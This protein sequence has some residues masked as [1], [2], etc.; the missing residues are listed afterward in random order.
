MLR[1]RTTRLLLAVATVFVVTAGAAYATGGLGAIIGADG[2]I[3]ACYKRSNGD[4]H[5]V[6][7][8]ATACPSGQ[9][10]IA[11]SQTGPKGDKGDKGDTGQQGI[12]GER[13]TAGANGTNGVSGYRINSYDFT[14]TESNTNTSRSSCDSDEV[15]V[16]GG[17]WLFTNPGDVDIPPRLIQSAPIDARTW[18]VKIDN[19]GSPRTWNYR[20][21]VICVRAS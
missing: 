14:V 17:A 18:E 15:L 6:P 12:Q 20:L 9:A 1:T 3:H 11:W 4:L 2:V 8:S 10:P 13:G 19:L 21:Q 5:V 7:A 16:S